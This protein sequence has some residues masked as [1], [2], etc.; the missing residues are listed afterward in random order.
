[1]ADRKLVSKLIR[2][3][4]ARITEATKAEL[5]PATLEA[6]GK[7]KRRVSNDGV[8]TN[9]S[10]IGKYSRKPIRVSVDTPAPQKAK[11]KGRGKPRAGKKKGA[12]TRKVDGKDEP[13]KTMY[14]EDGWA[15]FREFQ[16]R[17]A[18]TVNLTF[19]GDL[20]GSLKTGSSGDTATIAFTNKHAADKASG[21]EKRFGK[22]VFKLSREERAGVVKR[23]KD[24][25]RKGARSIFVP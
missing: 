21:N 5:L 24:A 7:L 22:T 10:P 2:L 14:F 4:K 17:Q 6:E 23:L 9:G 12:T 15:G 13:L 3:A 16:G 18:D 1:M 8:A 19:T 11:M 20:M 25:A